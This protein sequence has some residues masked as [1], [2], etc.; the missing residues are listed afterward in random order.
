[1]FCHYSITK[2][3][4][5]NLNYEIIIDGEDFVKT[6]QSII[7]IGRDG[8]ENEISFLDNNISRKNAI[9]LLFENENWIYELN[10]TDVFVDGVQVYFRKRLYHHHDIRIGTHLIQIKV[11]K[12]KLF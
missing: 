5:K 9:L 12:S 4:K 8:Y 2:A 10:G 3:P 11:D 7:P 1:M 6:Y